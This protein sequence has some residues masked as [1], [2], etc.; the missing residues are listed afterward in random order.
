MTTIEDILHN[1]SNPKIFSVVDAGNGYWH[2]EM[3]E[4]SSKLTTFITP[5]GRYKWKR[6][7]F[8][9]ASASEEY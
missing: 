1:L 2:V 9:I 8:G 3:D 4:N 6:L 7:P 5:Y